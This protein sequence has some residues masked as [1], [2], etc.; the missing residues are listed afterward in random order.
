MIQLSEVTKRYGSVQALGGVSLKVNKGEVLGL[1]GQNGAGKTTLL[2]I[3][4]GYLAPTSGTAQIDGYDSLLN[5]QEAKRRMGYLPEHPPLYD[6]M[7]VREYLTFAAELR[8]VTRKAIPAH[9]DEVMELTGLCEMRGRLLGHLSKG[10][11]QR[12]GFAQ[13]ICGDPDVLVLDEPT[14]GLDPKQITEIRQL[15]RSLSKGRTIIFSSHILTE[16]QQLCD[17]VVILHH[18]LVKLDSPMA[19]LGQGEEITLQLRAAAAPG[20]LLPKLRQ[21]DGVTAVTP[22]PTAQEGATEVLLTFH[23]VEDPERRLF[24]LMSHLGAPILHLSRQGDSLEQI[25]LS[26][27]SG[28]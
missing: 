10:Y 25:F 8:G 22:Q 1:L 15:I 20:M 4:T 5:P 2:N 26:A 18:G 12:A 19:Q 6:E 21:L 14:V 13:A 16:V 24:A 9:V 28:D 23:R 7:T 11:R 27:I 17:H 3:L